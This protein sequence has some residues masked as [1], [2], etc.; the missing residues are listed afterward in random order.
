MIFLQPEDGEQSPGRHRWVRLRVNIPT[1]LRPG[2]WYPV[3]SVG[4][5]EAV[6]DVR[7]APTILPRD[8]VEIFHARPEAWSLVPA[9]MGGPYLVCPDCAERVPITAANGRLTCPYCHSSYPI[10]SEGESASA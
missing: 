10:T 7:G 6:L 9:E 1:S 3:L 4:T 5:E 2:E 8:V